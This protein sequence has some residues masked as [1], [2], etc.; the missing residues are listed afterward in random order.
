MKVAFLDRDGTI[1]KDYPDR[2]WKYI[3]N[4]EFLKGSI[5][6]LQKII[7]KDYKIIIITNQYIIGEGIISEESY[8]KFS[9]KFI[10]I[11]EKSKIDIL[12]TFFCP[13]A[14]NEDCECCKPKPGLIFQALRKYTN[15][16]LKKSFLCGN[17]NCDFELAK[18]FN[19]KYFNIN[20]KINNDNSFVSLSSIIEYI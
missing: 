11:L 10:N 20:H 14:S 17:S 7:E 5:Y 18:Y 12:D 1:I 9:E 15:I 8:Y 3:Y 6:A 19:L 4:P 16:D 13:H 2:Y